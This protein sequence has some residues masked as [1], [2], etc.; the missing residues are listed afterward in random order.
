[1]PMYTFKRTDSYYVYVIADN[2]S[3]AQSFADEK[4][5]YDVDDSDIEQG[6][7]V[8]IKQSEE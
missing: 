7:W 8:L 2:K 1:M 5:L 6:T 4:T 3:E